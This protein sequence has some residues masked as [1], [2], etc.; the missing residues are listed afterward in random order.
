MRN[1]YPQDYKG[2]KAGVSGS[3][4]WLDVTEFEAFKYIRFG[5][6]RFSDFD[7]WLA[8]RDDWHYKRGCD[9]VQKAFEEMYKITGIFPKDK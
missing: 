5:I 7:C 1:D 8:A 3:Q 2:P 9:D 4:E 6:W